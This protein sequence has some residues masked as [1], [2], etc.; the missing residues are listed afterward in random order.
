MDLD[1]RTKVRAF[2]R[3]LLAEHDDQAPFGDVE[4]LIKA[5]RL[6]SL[7]VAKIVMFL[8]EAFGV[9]FAKV[10][11]DPERLDTVAEIEALI[12]ES[13]ERA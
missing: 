6:D 12:D 9:D 4:S 8:E 11:F 3:R 1:D 2:L 10:E 5:G 7:A 13:R